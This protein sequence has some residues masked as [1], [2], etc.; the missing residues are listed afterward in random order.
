PLL[1]EATATLVATAQDL[2]ERGPIEDGVT[3]MM[4]HLAAL[5]SHAQAAPPVASE[6]ILQTGSVEAVAAQARFDATLAAAQAEAQRERER[7]E[8]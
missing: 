8:Q 7:Q 5:A 6:P 2:P 4:R 1:A 3:R